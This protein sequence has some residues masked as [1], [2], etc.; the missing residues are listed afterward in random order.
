MNDPHYI[1]VIS[2]K[3]E[4]F[5]LNEQNQYILMTLCTSFIDLVGKI[6]PTLVIKV[7]QVIMELCKNLHHCQVILF[8]AEQW[9]YILDIRMESKIRSQ[10]I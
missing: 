6:T 10:Q 9:E 5:L 2:F 4:H 7:A 8:R 1:P 3:I